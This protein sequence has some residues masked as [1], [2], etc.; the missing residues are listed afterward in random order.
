M[1]KYIWNAGKE[2]QSRTAVLMEVSSLFFE[3]FYLRVTER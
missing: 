3:A 1:G 2:S